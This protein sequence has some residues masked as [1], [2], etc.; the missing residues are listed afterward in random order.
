MDIETTQRSVVLHAVRTH[1][2]LGN[3]KRK[4]DINLSTDTTL[5]G[6]SAK[7][8]VREEILEREVEQLKMLNKEVLTWHQ[9]NSKK[10]K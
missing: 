2:L 3:Q 5:E 6:E 9:E 8:T 4:P 1:I 7:K 10:N